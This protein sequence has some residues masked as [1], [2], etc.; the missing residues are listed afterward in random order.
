LNSTQKRYCPVEIQCKFIAA[1]DRMQF[2]FVG[3]AGDRQSL[4][5]GICPVQKGKLKS[6]DCPPEPYRRYSDHGGPPHR[7]RHP[8]I[9]A[10]QEHELSVN[11]SAAKAK[12]DGCTAAPL[13]R[14]SSAWR[15]RG[16]SA[17]DRRR[18]CA[19]TVRR[20]SQAN[21]RPSCW[22]VPASLRR[23]VGHDRVNCGGG[24]RNQR[25]LDRI[26][27]VDSRRMPPT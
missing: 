22:R 21:P 24:T 5:E 16:F 15:A 4:P 12:R 2:N 3:R 23:R 7:Q 20:H 1:E 13:R 25:A 10:E 11:V 14:S 18:R 27:T 19:P 9:E 6:S 26:Q 17:H 8:A